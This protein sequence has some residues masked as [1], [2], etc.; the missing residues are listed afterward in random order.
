M[1]GSCLVGL[2]LYFLCT[3]LQRRKKKKTGRFIDS[4]DDDDD[5][6]KIEEELAQYNLSRQE[7]EM[8]NLDRSKDSKKRVVKKKKKKDNEEDYF[9]RQYGTRIMNTEPE[10]TMNDGRIQSRVQN[11]TGDFYFSSQRQE[12]EPQNTFPLP[13]IKT[14]NLH[15]S[16]RKRKEKDPIAPATKSNGSDFDPMAPGFDPRVSK[17]PLKESSSVLGR[18]VT[19]EIV[20]DENGKKYRKVKVIKKVLKKKPRNDDE[21][22][23]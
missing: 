16:R 7:I 15:S 8:Q 19:S 4:D 22:D 3:W 5:E 18:T 6:D 17:K 9:K 20:E 10:L 1:V 2:S 11:T 23:Y 21:G 12:F 13:S 14:S